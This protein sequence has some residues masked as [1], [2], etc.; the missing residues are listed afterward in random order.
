MP[1][2][3]WKKRISA[4]QGIAPSGAIPRKPVIDSEWWRI[5]EMPDLGDLAGPDPKRQNVVDHSFVRA[6]NG[7]WQ[8]WACIRG[9]SVGRVIYGWQGDSLESGP[10]APDGVK[11][12]ANTDFGESAEGVETAGAPYFIE[13][14]DKYWCFYHSAGLHAMTSDDGV[15]FERVLNDHGSSA[16]LTKAGRDAMI[17]EIDALY[18]LYLTVSTVSADGW[19]QSFVAL[20][21]TSDFIEWSD[22]AIVSAGGIGGN[23]GVSAES[24]FVVALDGYYYMF[25]ASSMDFQTYVYRS[26]TPWNFG[27]NDDSKLIAVLP[28]KAPE[29]VLDAGLY[30]ISD[31]ADFQGIKMSKLRW[32]ED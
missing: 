2:I 31:L 17:I 32:D 24:P 13:V 9:V 1:E 3:N 30:Y 28:I 8:L 27:V 14:G 22:Y 19:G 21:T 4:A 18:H 25:R 15:N 20:R 16:V 10:W 6:K 29:I 5:C 23:G 11:I 12:R 26:T 7:K